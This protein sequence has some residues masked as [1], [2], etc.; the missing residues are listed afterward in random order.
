MTNRK[1]LTLREHL[2]TPP[3][4]RRGQRRNLGY[5]VLDKWQGELAFENSV[6]KKSGPWAGDQGNMNAIP[7]RF[8]LPSGK[9]RPV[10]ELMM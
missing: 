8:K 1:W 4:R 7:S 10:F 3:E 9:P 6:F 2:L 5:R